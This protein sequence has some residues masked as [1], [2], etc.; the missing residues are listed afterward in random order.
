M[1]KRRGGLAKAGTVF[2][3]LLVAL[4]LTSMGYG[5][6]SDTLTISGTLETGTQSTELTCSGNY[7]VPAGGLISCSVTDNV[8]TVTVTN[9]QLDV[10]YYCDFN[11]QNTGDIPV[12]IQSIVVSPLP[13]VEEVE[14]EIQDVAVGDQLEQNG[15][16]GDTVYGKVHVSLLPEPPD[17]PSK[18]TTFTFTVTFSVVQWDQYVP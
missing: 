2:L 3:A 17:N 1:Q 13:P 15:V 14:V 7:T 16:T 8:L 12:K 11:I 6:W 18:N 4:V 9:T 5:I 10:N